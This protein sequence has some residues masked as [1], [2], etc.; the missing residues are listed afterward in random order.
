MRFLQPD[1]LMWG[2]ALA[3]LV[4]LGWWMH[5]RRRRRLA[6]FL[7]GRRAATRLARANLYRL[8]VERVLLLGLA[9]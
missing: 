3:L 1:F 8:Q 6:E 7:G 5:A 9:T 4:G 2:A